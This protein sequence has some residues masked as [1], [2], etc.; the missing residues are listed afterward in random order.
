MK[1]SNRGSFMAAKKGNQGAT[2]AVS[3][4]SSAQHAFCVT[5]PVYSARVAVAGGGD[6]NQTCEYVAE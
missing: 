2:V 4:S 6:G 1:E 3:S 5:L